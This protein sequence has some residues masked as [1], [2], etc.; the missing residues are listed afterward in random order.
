MCGIYSS[1]SAGISPVMSI[2]I[3]P[4][5]ARCQKLRI[6]SDLRGGAAA[7][8]NK[9]YQHANDLILIRSEDIAAR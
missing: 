4:N 9:F 6:L 1:G 8:C 2:H 7:K 3:M 5:H